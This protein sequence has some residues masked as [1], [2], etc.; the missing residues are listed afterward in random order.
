MGRGIEVERPTPWRKGKN[1]G[2]GGAFS[3]DRGHFVTKIT[4][5]MR[6]FALLILAATLV[7]DPTPELTAK[8][9]KADIERKVKAIEATARASSLATPA[10]QTSK[11]EPTKVPRPTPS[12]MSK[13]RGELA[14]LNAY[15]YLAGLSHDVVLDDELSWTCKFGAE[16]CRQIGTIDHTPPKP[17]GMDDATYRRGYEGTSKSNLYWTSG[18]DGLTGSVDAY[19]DDSDASNIARV[20]HRRWCLNPAM[21]KTGFGVAGGASAMWA[22]DGAGKP[23]RNVIISFPA[24]GFYPLAYLK[25]NTAWSVSLSPERYRVAGTKVKLYELSAASQRRFP[26]DLKG[27]KEIPLSDVRLDTS[28]IGVAQCLIFRPKTSFKRGDRVGV[29]IEDV[30]GLPDKRLAYVVELF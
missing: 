18:P 28:M 16:I 2:S 5:S 3:L 20:G 4:R 29:L 17:K 11:D 12:E 8:R 7:A 1:S 13:A 6:P 19:M 26:A 9:S 24:A 22:F 14:R 27:L 25:P 30:Q 15:R 23:A 21:A 10:R